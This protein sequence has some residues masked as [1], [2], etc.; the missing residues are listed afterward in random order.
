LRSIWILL[1]F[2]G[3]RSWN[4]KTLTRLVVVI[5]VVSLAAAFV[6]RPSRA[7]FCAIDPVA[8][9]TLLLPYFELG[10]KDVS[11]NKLKGENTKLYIRNNDAAPTLARVTL[12]TELS[13]P[14]LAFSFGR[15][16][17]LVLGDGEWGG[18][19]REFTALSSTGLSGDGCA[20]HHVRISDLDGDGRGEIVASFGEDPGVDPACGAGGSLRA[21]LLAA[22]SRPIGR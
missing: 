4:I 11:G 15:R 5:L 10:E 17:V 13:V 1:S 9:A 22:G 18:T 20:G 7:E 16:D 21:W 19:R 14:T 12:W 8:A 3:R 6:S 2:S